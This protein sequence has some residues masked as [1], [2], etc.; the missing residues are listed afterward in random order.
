MFVCCLVSKMS[1]ITL[2]F[3]I[4]RVNKKEF[5]KSKEPI[6]LMPV[7]IDEIVVFDKFK[8][9]DQGYKYFIGYQEDENVKTCLFFVRDDNV[10][11]KY[12]EI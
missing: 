10:L 9:S 7:N 8:H 6:D 3:D 11:D 5:H 4:I 1:K 2:K 12:N